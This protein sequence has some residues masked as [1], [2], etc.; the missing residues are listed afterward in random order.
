MGTTQ[1]VQLDPV[2]EGA[3][4]GVGLVQLLA[5]LAADVAAGGQ[6]GER[7]QGGALAQRRVGAAVDELE[8]LDG[9]LDVAQPARPELELTVDLA[10]RDVL[11]DPTPH[12]LHVPDEAVPLGSAPHHRLE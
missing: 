11:D 1:L 4:E 6:P 12:R 3:Q 9:E 7:A 5:V 10:R 2:L 8:Q